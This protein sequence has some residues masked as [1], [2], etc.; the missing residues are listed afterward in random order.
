MSLRT[1]YNKAP[2]YN[3]PQKPY[4]RVTRSGKPIPDSVELFR[5]PLSERESDA[6]T[7]QA[8][9]Y[10]CIIFTPCCYCYLLHEMSMIRGIKVGSQQLTN[11]EVHHVLDPLQ[12]Y[13]KITVLP[14][15]K[16]L[17]DDY[18]FT[19]VCVQEDTMVC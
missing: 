9:C 7:C 18:T 12:G 15:A 17:V 4:L 1:L 19:T 14:S 2:G 6:L 16:D 3:A 13:W 8:C 10:G 5:M 11:L